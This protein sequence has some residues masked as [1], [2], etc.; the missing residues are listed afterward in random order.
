MRLRFHGWMVLAGICGGSAW[1][2]DAS[3]DPGQAFA[4][5]T[6]CAE[7]RQALARHPGV[8]GGGARVEAICA[9]E[10]ARPRHEPDAQAEIRQWHRDNVAAI[11][12][13]VRGLMISQDPRDQLAAALL[14]PT[15]QLE[16]GEA[17]GEWTTDA[18]TTAFAAA[19]RLGPDDPLVAWMEALDCPGAKAAAGCD[20]HAAMQRLQR[21]APDNTA[22]WLQ[23]L[24]DAL[25]EP[26]VER[27]LSRAAAARR[28]QLPLGELGL[29]L[30]DALD[31]ADAPPMSPRLATAMAS[32][33]GL[34]RPV[35]RRDMTAMHAMA[36]TTAVVLPTYARLR[37]ACIAEDDVPA[38]AR[39]HPDCI[40]IYTRMAQSELLISRALALASLV[41][42]TADAPEGAHWRERLRELHW[43]WHSGLEPVNAQA[44]ADYILTSWR[45]GEMAALEGV[46]AAAGSPLA[47]PDG[48]LPEN[49]RLRSLITTGRP[50]ARD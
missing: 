28:Y 37:H 2:G 4:G 10:A 6:T 27:I 9:A 49:E 31:Q 48:W 50:P 41:R 47:P 8:T 30:Y 46:L 39:R 18:A 32:D 43:L 3:S 45:K 16:G 15:Y 42:L 5:V 25:D 20:P 14:A 40:G 12:Q 21:L 34:A 17:A 23:Q 29:L 19:R 13:Q 26:E 33:M 7:A 11:G 36:L 1:A 24:R 35:G 22:V 38:P 44:P